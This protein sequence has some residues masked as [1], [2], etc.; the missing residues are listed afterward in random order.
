MSS[1]NKKTATLFLSIGTAILLL[2]GLWLHSKEVQMKEYMYSIDSNLTDGLIGEQ[3]TTE[4]VTEVAV[5]DNGELYERVDDT[6]IGGSVELHESRI[7]NDFEN[8][9][10]SKLT[11]SVLSGFSV[12]I[13]IIGLLSMV[14]LLRKEG[15]I[16]TTEVATTLL[17]ISIERILHTQFIYAFEVIVLLLLL[18]LLPYSIHDII[19]WCSRRFSI[20]DCVSHRIGTYLS[21]RNNKTYQY[22]VTV[23]VWMF[24]NIIICFVFSYLV[25]FEESYGENKFII[26]FIIISLINVILALA[27]LVKYIRQVIHLEKQIERLSA[28]ENIEISSGIYENLERRLIS[29]KDERD[30]AIDEALKSERFKVDLITNVSHDLRTPLTSILGYGELLTSE[31][32]SPLGRERLDCLNSKTE[33]MKNLVDEL[34]EL[35]KISSGVIQPKNEEIDLI[36]L[37]EQTIGLFE[38]KLV[39]AK[40]TI[41]RH[42]NTDSIHIKTDGAM[43]HQIFANLLG[44]AIKYSP[45]ESRIHIKVAKDDSYI[46]LRM[47]NVSS[48][49][50]DFTEEEITK[51]FVRGD[52][53]R[54][55]SGSGIGLA[56]V[57]TYADALG[58]EFH[59]EIDDE[60]FVAVV[61]LPDN[62]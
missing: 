20:E 56:I 15:V 53:A 42:F 51:R 52:K 40:L 61:K 2:L 7:L 29:L 17:M 62:N 18:F 12:V 4:M 24:I 13:G 43:L 47:S 6:N 41:K 60:Q 14:F 39:S 35:T 34:F 46:L 23:L 5:D 33:Y 22:P 32:L 31:E 48:Y 28:G 21:K 59:V 50:M 10:K 38:D 16:F 30:M 8:A 54:S 26:C 37:I 57:K 55:T 58:G 11:Y 25:I 44:N 27:T 3:T 9:K 1:K 36:K 19:K 45:V 49:E